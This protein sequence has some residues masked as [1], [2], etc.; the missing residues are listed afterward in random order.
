VP[1]LTRLVRS[2]LASESVP[3]KRLAG[4][5]IGVPGIIDSAS[6]TILAVSNM[7]LTGVSLAGALKKEL[8]VPVAIEN[9]VK[10][11]LLGEHWLGAAQGCANAVGLFIGTGIGG[12]IILENQLLTGFHHPTG[13]FGHA[14]VALDGP[15]C[16]C[17]SRGC[18][19]ALAGRWAIER[20]IK[21]ALRAGEKSAITDICGKNPPSIKSRALAEALKAGDPLVT[22]VLKRASKAIGLSCISIQRTIDPEVIVLGGGVI[23]ACG[24]FIFPIVRKTAAADRL[25]P[26]KFAC[27][28]VL[29]RLGDEAIIFGAVALIKRRLG[30]TLTDEACPF[31]RLMKNGEISAECRLF[32]QDIYIRAD[33]RIKK[34]ELKEVPEGATHE[35]DLAEV[36]KI[37]KKKPG[38]LII[39]AGHKRTLQITAGAHAYLRNRGIRSVSL[40]T[41]EAIEL[42]NEKRSNRA[43]LIHTA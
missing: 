40:S 32:D 23:E 41:P 18:L 25:L 31:V 12:A 6:G 38:I 36:Q 3:F 39:G 9:D 5:G 28:V 29:S 26:E 20:D 1:L 30:L 34:R 16:G 2:L 10:A 14:I 15:V 37:C 43:I 22:K 27:R 42:Y 17:G 19:E 7:K 33:G 11:G 21:D 4:I 24:D 13:E 35:I 8:R